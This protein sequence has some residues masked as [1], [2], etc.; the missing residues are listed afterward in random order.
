MVKTWTPITVSAWAWGWHHIALTLRLTRVNRV[1]SILP[2]LTLSQAFFFVDGKAM[3]DDGSFL[4]L[5]V[6]ATLVLQTGIS[7]LFVG[8]PASVADLHSLDGAYSSFSGSMD[9][10]R[11][12]APECAPGPSA[13]N[14]YGFLDPQDPV[15]NAASSTGILGS[16]VGLQLFSPPT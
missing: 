5:N 10:I 7:M 3:P 16:Q 15:R 14:P 11:L 12:W 2:S 9:A 4:G 1:G 8:G 13:C 6:A